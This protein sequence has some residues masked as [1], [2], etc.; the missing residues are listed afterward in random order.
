MDK[1]KIPFYKRTWFIIVMMFLCFPIGLL[2]FWLNGRYEL[3]TKKVVTIII[4]CIYPILGFIFRSI[5]KNVFET[6]PA[7][8]I[9]QISQM[10]S[11]AEKNGT[12]KQTIKKLDD[13][14]KEQAESEIIA[15]VGNTLQKAY[16]IDKKY[17]YGAMYYDDE[18]DKDMT[19][20][21]ASK[22]KK[23]RK[24]RK[25]TNVQMGFD[26]D[27]GTWK[28]AVHFESKEKSTQK[29]IAVEDDY[30]LSVEDVEVNAFSSE[31]IYADGLNEF[32]NQS[33][34]IC[35][36]HRCQSIH[37]E[38]SVDYDGTVY[39]YYEILCQRDNALAQEMTKEMSDLWNHSAYANDVMTDFLDENTKDSDSNRVFYRFDIIDGDLNEYL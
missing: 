3:K 32:I 24:K 34:A 5:S 29:E 14:T 36:N 26:S 35:R 12:T 7:N 19:D 13:K 31:K 9:S 33:I 4:I 23:W 37:I 1:L 6:F 8:D 27:M 10:D 17:G 15:T 18:S 16:A 38:R 25:V 39:V 28:C 22:S 21:I 30:E 2:L 20:K 11:N